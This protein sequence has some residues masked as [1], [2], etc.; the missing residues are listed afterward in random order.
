MPS[1]PNGPC[2]TGKTTSAPSSPPPGSSASGS[3]RRRVQRAVAADQ[4]PRRVS[5]PASL[6]PVAHRRGRRRARPRARSSARRRAPP[7]SRRAP[8][9]PGFGRSPEISTPTMIVTVRALAPL[10]AH[11]GR[12]ARARRPRRV[13]PSCSLRT[14]PPKPASRSSASASP[15]AEP[16]TSGTSRTSA[17]RDEDRHG[18][19]L[20]H[21][22]PAAGVC[23]ITVS[24][25]S[26]DAR[27]AHDRAQPL[28]AQQRS[29]DVARLADHVRH[30]HLLRAPA[31][32]QRGRA[33]PRS[34][35]SPAAGIGA[36]HDALGD[37][38]RGSRWS[39]VA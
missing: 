5:W 3:A 33:A 38:V 12:L 25:G 17:V 4:R 9:V 22:V 8:L 11:A 37:L 21:L 19:A 34:T 29:A 6:Q 31:D 16:V 20:V 24:T 30:R 15:A 35:S 1:S 26:L 28:V 39:T 23:S 10:G 18:R 14:S 32:D 27:L 13:G 36:D 7:P 2:S